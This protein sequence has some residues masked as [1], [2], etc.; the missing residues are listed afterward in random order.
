MKRSISFSLAVLM[1]FVL[2][3]GCAQRQETPAPRIEEVKAPE[4]KAEEVVTPAQGDKIGTKDAP[5]KVTVLT[6]DVTPTDEQIQKLQVQI[7]EGMA[8][9]G[10][11]I[12]LEFLEPPVGRYQEVVPLAFRT[13]QIFPDIIYF[14]GGDLP[15]AQE[16]MLEDLTA[17]INN[18][19][20]VKKLMQEHNIDAIANY[21][22]LLWLAPPRVRVP[23]IRRDWFES[24]ESSSA[25]L[26][27]PTVENY[28]AMFKELTQ[29][30]SDYAFT[31]DGNIIRL[32]SI[33]NHAFG[34]T[35]TIMNI[36]GKH[37]YSRAT[38]F[39]RD[40]LAFYAQL[41]KEGLL[42]SEFI[43]MGWEAMEQAFYEGRVG[44][45]AG[46]AGD[47][48]GIYN[49]KMVQTNGAAAELVVLPPAKGVS[50]AYLSVDVTKESRGFAINAD[51]NVKEAAWAVLE[52]MASPAGRKLDNI[53]LKDIH[54]TEVDGKITLTDKFPE[55]WEKF[56]P[57]MKDFDTANIIGEVLNAPALV[58][59]DSASEFYASDVNVILP[60]HLL[61]L[62]DAMNNLY[63]EYST[64]IIKG[65]RSIDS[66]D[67]F[68]TNWNA[69]GGEVIS[70]YLAEQLQ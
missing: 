12:D 45:I 26:E 61:P 34:I 24:L 60:S 70:I 42:D 29:K 39:E 40:K 57:T 38:Q 9:E 30:F 11:Y 28:L 35:S 49:N 13:G 15:L 69:A 58:S 8:A 18:S 52:F 19:N 2:F 47:V 36:D 59:L 63:I 6:K 5:V 7:E 31:T 62:M 17:Y 27:N 20:Y 46:T 32:D 21:P 3:T 10:N 54:Y 4:P 68:V 33:F 44:V 37:V 55:W 23:V 64:D 25:L 1:A 43:T 41:F 67:E 51:S 22:Y 66:F 14:Q 16:G 48:V 65:V 56:W 53:G 50:H